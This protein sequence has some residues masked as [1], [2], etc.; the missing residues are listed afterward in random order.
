VYHVER[1]HGTPVLILHGAGVDHREPLGTMEP[2]FAGTDGYRRIYPDLPGQ[3]KTPAP[4]SIRRADD[5]LD[6]LLGLVDD[7][8]GDGPLLVVGHSAGGYFAHAIA[9]RRPAQVVGLALICPLLERLRDI[10]DHAPVVREHLGAETSE[11]FRAYVVVQTPAT[12]RS[13]TD[14]VAPGVEAA[15]RTALERIGERWRLTAGE[16]EGAYPHPVLV[17]VGR[18]DSSVGYAGQWD[19]VDAYPRSTFA[20]LDRAGHALPHEQPELLGAL[21]REWLRRVEER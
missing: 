13:Y 10:P 21:L 4:P 20:M 18:Q 2:A 1:G 9:H 6:A 14:H 11:A 7:V 12:L 5:V 16:P 3:G 17:L 19:L 8:A 15:D